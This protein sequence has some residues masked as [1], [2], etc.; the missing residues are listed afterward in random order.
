M[1]SVVM[2]DM[3]HLG[4]I[5][6]FSLIMSVLSRKKYSPSLK[7]HKKSKF[8]SPKIEPEKSESHLLKPSLMSLQKL[9]LTGQ[10]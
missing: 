4:G 3:S 2:V 10:V 6:C 1:G 8:E 5:D 9:S 7:T